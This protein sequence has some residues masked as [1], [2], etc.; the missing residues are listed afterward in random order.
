[1]SSVS[2]HPE[3]SFPRPLRLAVAAS[4]ALHGVALLSRF[5]LPDM[6]QEAPPQ[7]LNIVLRSPQPQPVPAP[8]IAPAPQPAQAAAPRI[9]E[10]VR[11]PE[12]QPQREAVLTRPASAD[13][14]IPVLPRRDAPQPEQA[15]V[16]ISPPAPVSAPARAAPATEPA[17]APSVAVVPPALVHPAVD[18]APDPAL[19]ER[20][21]RSLSSLF[22]R[23]QQYPRLAALRGWEGE[24]QLRVTIAR[25]GNIIATQ[26]VRSSGF[27]VLD[28]NAIQLVSSSG[29]LPRPPDALQNKELQ[30]IV[31]VLFKLEKPT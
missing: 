27:E 30:I 11:K 22:A 13:R 20:Y 2:I 10:P 6:Q 12:P 1:M 5:G 18:E 31:P 16:A 21:G 9:T 25:K 26:I 3:L 19:L 4:I 8:V 24:V 28:Q 15:S 29:P 23:Q 17:P 14:P 7:P